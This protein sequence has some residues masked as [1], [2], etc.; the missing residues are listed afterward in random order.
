M[1]RPDKNSMATA[2]C[3]TCSSGTGSI[4]GCNVPGIG[5][6]KK[7]EKVR[8]DIRDYVLNML[9]A[10]R[11]K[12]E[13]TEQNLDFC[14]NQALKI[15]EDYA[16]SD[17][18]DYKVFDTVPG[19]SVYEMPPEVGFIR[20]VSYKTMGTL[21]FTA[22]DLGGAIPIE[23]ATGGMTYWGGGVIDPSQ[24][25]WGDMG[26]WFVFKTYEQMFSKLSSQLGSWEWI[27]GH[28]K[29]KLYP[30]PY[31]VNKVIIHYLQRC[32]DW[33]EVTQAM[34]EGALIYAK[35]ILGRIRGMIKNPPGPGGGLQLDGDQLLQEARED[36][37]QW[38]EDLVSR[39]GDLSGPTFG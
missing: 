11:L 32:K 20:D 19:Q 25:I 10:P 16:P 21:A 23:Y 1:G 14:I 24:P 28:R 22:Q 7:R 18:F 8:E 2:Q 13:L 26:S 34:Q 5:P 35:E 3:S 12:L 27:G 30:T 9:G 31:K 17:Y 29:I 38:L 4:S 36:K 33:E 39:W 15:V 37:R 6:R